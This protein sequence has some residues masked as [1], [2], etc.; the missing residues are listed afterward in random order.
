ME[1]GINDSN[2]PATPADAA[3][4]GSGARLECQNEGLAAHPVLGKI[5]LAGSELTIGR[6]DSNAITLKADGVSRAHARLYAGDGGWGIEDLNSTNGVLVN[7][8]RVKKSWL[9]SGDTVLIGTV[10]YKYLTS[11]QQ[12]PSSASPAESEE[13]P[14]EKTVIMRPTIKQQVTA[15]AGRQQAAAPPQVPHAKATAPTPT[16]K[17]VVKP[18]AGTTPA[19]KPAPRPKPTESRGHLWMMIIGVALVL[20]FLF[21]L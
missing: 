18:R 6:G 17:P 16:P 5:Q 20:G 4:A 1:N 8:S 21:L 19:R 12:P 13:D 3:Q 9:K 2:T 10:T 7:G 15:Q 11:A 14:F